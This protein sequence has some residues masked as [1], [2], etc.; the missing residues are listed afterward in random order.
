[1]PAVLSEQV[2]TSALPH[3]PFTVP[4]PGMTFEDYLE[5]QS[6]HIEIQVLAMLLAD[7][8]TPKSKS[9]AHLVAINRR[10]TRF[11]VQPLPL[12]A[13][14]LIDPNGKPGILSPFLRIQELT[15]LF[16]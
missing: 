14:D 12:T 1:M 13:L 11:P 5:Y 6:W 9:L 3:V 2:V 7:K 15:Q 4:I 8:T 10:A 16:T